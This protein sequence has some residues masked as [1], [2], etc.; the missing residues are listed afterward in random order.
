MYKIKILRTA[1]IDCANSVIF[2]DGNKQESTRIGC[3][4]FLIE[5]GEEYYLIDTGIE[6][7][8][9]ANKTK[10]SK[11]DWTRSDDE[12]AVKDALELFGVEC[13]RISKIFLTHSH[14]DH[15]SGIVH[16]PNATIYMTQK[17][18]E[19]LY[20]DDNP[21]KEYLGKAKTFLKDREVV[22]V[23]DE[24]TIDGITLKLRGGHTAGSMSIGVD[25]M[26][27]VGDTIFTQAN[28]EK[29]IPAGFT[30]DRKRSDELVE[31]YCNYNGRI[32]TSHDFKEKI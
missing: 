11:S 9:I 30:A 19:L 10:S 12:Y 3:H 20:A 8:D 6:D 14:Y 16:F 15:I 13:S 1:H 23:D 32:I 4:S 18:W 2:N 27:F 25:N 29:S 17:E 28:I 31:I 21:L 7:I 24:L 22:L 5:R 26:L